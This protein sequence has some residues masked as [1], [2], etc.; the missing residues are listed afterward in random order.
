MPGVCEHVPLGLVEPA[1]VL[2]EKIKRAQA[3]HHVYNEGY[4]LRSPGS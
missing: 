3:G 4:F 1:C 2:P